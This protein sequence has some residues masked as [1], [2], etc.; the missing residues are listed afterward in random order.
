MA[1]EGDLDAVAS[2]IEHSFTG[3]PQAEWRPIVADASLGGVE[4]LCVGEKQGRVVASCKIYR[5]EQW[6]G[7]VAIPIMGLGFVAIA[8]TERR[9]GIG[10]EL[11]QFALDRARDRGDLGSALYPFRTSFYGK[12]GYGIAGNAIQYRIQPRLLPDDPGRA[13]VQ[14]V[15][16]DQDHRAVAG[17]YAAWIPTQNGQIARRE[18][19]WASFRD[20]PSR[21]TVLY[22][23][24]QGEPGG[25]ATFRYRE[26]SAG[27]STDLDLVE[28][29]WK[30]HA[31]R[32]ALY[33]WMASLSDQW[34][35]LLYRAHPEEGFEN[36]LRE[37]RL[38]ERPDPTWELWAPAAHWM[39]GPMFRLID[40]GGA[41]ERRSL[42]A[43][44]QLR[45]ALDV[46]DEQLPGNTGRWVWEL[47]AD[48][49]TV[50]KGSQRTDLEMEM[51]ISTLSRI[52]IGALTPS[53]AV[54]AELATVDDPSR[55]PDLDQ[56]LK[57]RLPW[58]FERF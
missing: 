13:R 10:A 7:G 29:V 36:Y 33:G 30:D 35:H 38:N 48:A 28:V 9:R 32:R 3:R 2:L 55:L 6:I 58:S 50:E 47:G 39:T 4:V 54:A 24:E 5:M 14:L 41:L 49:S 57:L 22:R 23:D 26:K 51:G 16:S 20:D 42:R 31:A 15:E 11:V 46:H 52:Y 12:V 27:L 37:L 17:L 34:R 40:V 53:A 45:V 18:A 56:R 25:Y 43:G 44:P 1:T 21:H 8:P 19:L